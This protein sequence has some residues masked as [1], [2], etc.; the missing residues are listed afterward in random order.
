MSLSRIFAALICCGAP[1]VASAHEFWIEPQSYQVGSG[2]T[3]QAD[4]KNGQMFKGNSL[5][6]FERSS[7]R[8][9]MIAGG[10]VIT[11]EPRA[12][13]AP[14][15]NVTAPIDDGL[16]VVIHETTPSKL[17][18]KEWEKFQKFAARKDFAQAEA[19]HVAAG[20]SQS[21]FR[22]VY[23]RH[24]K[25]LLAVGMGSGSDMSTGMVTEFVALSNPYAEKFDNNMKVKVLYENAPRPDA[26]VEVFDRA[27]DDT[28]TI[29]LHRTDAQGVASIPV[30]PGHDYLFDAVVLRPAPDASTAE[31]AIVWETLWAALTF[32]VPAQ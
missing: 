4:F 28:V 8:F 29:H 13:D 19:D 1:V 10:E 32:S 22:E 17:T 24:A 14:A 23:T 30:Q 16:V 6:Y 5:S 26:Q 25:A 21:R 27:P 7:A 9:E 11:L 31:D 18:Y 12:G 2:E 3:L 15:L 20:W